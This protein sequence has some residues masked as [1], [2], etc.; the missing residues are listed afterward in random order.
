MQARK[1]SNGR[2]KEAFQEEFWEGKFRNT[3][4]RKDADLGPSTPV[5]P[6]QQVKTGHSGCPR[7]FQLEDSATLRVI[8]N[9]CTHTHTMHAI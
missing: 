5:H 9:V 1:K 6:Q 7:S 3:E 8:L 2:F 4:W